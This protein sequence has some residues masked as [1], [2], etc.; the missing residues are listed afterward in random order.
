M[1]KA[2]DA[3]EHGVVD[4]RRGAELLAPVDHAVA[5]DVDIGH[6]LDAL[7]PGLRRDDPAHD[8]VERRAVVSQRRVLLQRRAAGGLEVHQ[9]E[10]A[11]ALH[12]AGE[13]DQ[14]M[15]A[16]TEA[17][18]LFVEV[19]AGTGTWDPEVWLLTEW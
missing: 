14:A 7:D 6:G 1:Q 11:D 8:A 2:Q 18:R 13:S 17:V 19:R 15:A 16:L 10:A 12:L 4:D 3:F 5:D 9:R